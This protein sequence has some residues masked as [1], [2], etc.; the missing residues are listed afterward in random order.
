MSTTKCVTHLYANRLNKQETTNADH[1]HVNDKNARAHTQ[2]T[3]IWPNY[4]AKQCERSIQFGWGCI[5][6]ALAVLCPWTCV[7]YS[8]V[9]TPTWS[10][11]SVSRTFIKLTLNCGW[12]ARN[13][14]AAAPYSIVRLSDRPLDT[15]GA[16]HE[17]YLPLLFPSLLCCTPKMHRKNVD[18][19]LSC[20]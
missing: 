13:P 1:V 3:H 17:N 6:C 15:F 5:M 7:V 10:A 14:N 18:V 2:R 16:L 4:A 20:P 12:T 8:T 19:S 11:L 9:E